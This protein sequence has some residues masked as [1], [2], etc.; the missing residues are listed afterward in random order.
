MVSAWWPQK[1]GAH[2]PIRG[3][4]GQL[5]FHT[6][7]TKKT[8]S[9]LA[10][11]MAKKE[12]RSWLVSMIPLCGN[13]ASSQSSNEWIQQR[14][15]PFADQRWIRR[16]IPWRSLEVIRS[17]RENNRFISEDK[18]IID[19]RVKETDSIRIGSLI[20]LKTDFPPKGLSV[21]N[22][23]THQCRSKDI[24]HDRSRQKGK[25]RP[26]KPVCRCCPTPKKNSR[27]IVGCTSNRFLSLTKKKKNIP[28]FKSKY[29]RIRLHHPT[30]GPDQSGWYK[31]L[32][33]QTGGAQVIL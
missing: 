11:K 25:P 24:F 31:R 19:G 10:V 2:R 20:F 17:K 7:P 30:P 26:V 5:T 27:V 29:S 8:G 4:V 1:K 32:H 33:G 9:S 3:L 15:S 23:N 18:N 6:G 14:N 12:R 22:R 16:R 21:D 13:R 28:P